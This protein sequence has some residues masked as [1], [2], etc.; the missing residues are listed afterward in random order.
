MDETELKGTAREE[1]IQYDSVIAGDEQISGAWHPAISYFIFLPIGRFWGNVEGASVAAPAEEK[2][3]V[4][5][6]R[7]S[8]KERGGKYGGAV[9]WCES[10]DSDLESGQDTSKKSD[11]R[12][13]VETDIK[14]MTF[15]LK[16][17]A[18]EKPAKFYAAGELKHVW[19]MGK[20]SLVYQSM[21]GPSSTCSVCSY[22]LRGKQVAILLVRLRFNLDTVSEGINGIPSIFFVSAWFGNMTTLSA[23]H[24]AQQCTVPADRI[25]CVPFTVP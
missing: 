20:K 14:V 6:V 9:F 25:H 16:R 4:K 12:G 21:C 18:I 13:A 24:E 10:K 22:R 3:T 15:C 17:V 1:T 19:C 23:Q 8:A 5:N 7:A 2:S 11:D